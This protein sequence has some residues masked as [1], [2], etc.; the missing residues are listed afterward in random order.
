MSCKGQDKSCEILDGDVELVHVARIGAA[1]AMVVAAKALT[2]DV[3]YTRGLPNLF[4]LVPD[5]GL[6]TIN[7]EFWG[8]NE[9]CCGQYPC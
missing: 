1:A 8:E 6:G 7:F 2:S 5:C 3:G 9:W 4:F